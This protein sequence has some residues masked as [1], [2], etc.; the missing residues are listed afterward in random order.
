MN[1]YLKIALGVWGV[2]ILVG[3]GMKA[4]DAFYAWITKKE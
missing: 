4:F 2:L 1:E 3:F